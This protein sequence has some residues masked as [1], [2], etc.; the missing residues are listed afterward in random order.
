MVVSL[1]LE[2]LP[3]SMP[4]DGRK[5]AFGPP[6][7]RLH[8]G[9]TATT[10]GLRNRWPRIYRVRRLHALCVCLAAGL[11]LSA[12]PATPRADATVVERT[13]AAFD[14]IL[15]HH[16]NAGLTYGAL[17][18]AAIAGT[19]G[20]SHASRIAATSEIND[21]ASA[22]VALRDA[23]SKLAILRTNVTVQTLVESSFQ[24][25]GG[26]NRYLPELPQA[27]ARPASLGLEIKRSGQRTL[28][29]RPLP[30]GPA[31]AAGIAPDDELVAILEIAADGRAGAATS[32]SGLPLEA[33]VARLRGA[34]DSRVRLTI[35][36]G[37]R[38]PPLQV[39]IRRAEVLEPNTLS[40]VLPD[41]I[42]YLRIRQFNSVAAAEIADATVTV[43]QPSTD[44]PAGL[45]LDLRGNRGGLVEQ[46]VT[47][48]DHFL[49]QGIVASLAGRNPA[50]NR[51]IKA[52]PG[53]IAAGAPIVL[54]VDGETSDGAELF[55]AALVKNGR[56]RLVGTRT[57]G[58]AAVTTVYQ[59]TP[60]AGLLL[61]TGRWRD[62]AG[63]SWEG[64]GLTPEIVVAGAPS[65]NGDDAALSAA[66]RLFAPAR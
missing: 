32:L 24:A 3:V 30:R 19:F 44:R 47:A 23:L 6:W 42:G 21:R 66:A 55:A 45:I 41:R 49:E 11:A 34:P 1:R 17:T 39:D 31:E 15:T 25:A 37:D 4:A 18:T 56:A 54:L 38:S 64:V 28:V 29:H 33:V 5:V 27:A 58:L 65:K 14:V 13:L 36:R 48:A 26:R 8:L 22:G 20:P 60:P 10:R 63:V 35:R 40:R 7:V 62:P 51:E 50:D 12:I 9:V 57:K 53:E 52:T 59:A 16:E 61:Q 43:L 46:I 2:D